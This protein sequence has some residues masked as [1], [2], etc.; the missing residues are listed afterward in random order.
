V[1]S[2]HEIYPIPVF[3]SLTVKDIDKSLEWYH[4]MGFAAIFELRSPNGELMGA[5]VRLGKYQDFNLV[6]AGEDIPSPGSGVRVYLLKEIDD[7]DKFAMDLKDKGV[8]IVEGPV[9]RPWNLR[10]VV[11]AD[12]D[13]YRFVFGKVINTHIKFDE[14]VK[15]MREG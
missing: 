5:H 2:E 7:I 9:D 15:N 4:K 13:G 8:T 1:D 11:I 12:P 3:V 6:K 10:E 14:V